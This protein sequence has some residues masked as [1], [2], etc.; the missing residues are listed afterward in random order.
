MPTAAAIDG[1]RVN[2]SSRRPATA[3]STSVAANRTAN[4]LTS[5][6]VA[7]MMLEE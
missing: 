2:S 5:V 1:S 4:R 6:L 7:P 3:S